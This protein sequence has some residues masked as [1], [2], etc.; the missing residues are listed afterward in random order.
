M[1]YKIGDK[2]ETGFIF[3]IQGDT[4][5][6]CA[7]DDYMTWDEANKVYKNFKFY[8]WRLPTKE[9]LNLMYKNLHKKRNW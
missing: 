6:E 5:F 1:N 2:T 3:D 9:E 7:L 4:I 8:N